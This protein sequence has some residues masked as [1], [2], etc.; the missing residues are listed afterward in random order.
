MGRK[1]TSISNHCVHTAVLLLDLF[2][3]GL[4][5]LSIARHELYN[6]HPIGIF[7]LNDV[8]G[9]RIRRVAHSC[10]HESIVVFT[11][12]LIYKREA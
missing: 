4:V 5:S 8:E 12:N 2:S 10:I 1:Q 7:L 9:R 6:S 3:D 11:E